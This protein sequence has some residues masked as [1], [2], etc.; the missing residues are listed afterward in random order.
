MKHGIG[1][2]V[3]FLQKS[4]VPTRRVDDVLYGCL[5]CIHQGRTLDASDATVFIS[6]KALF[7]HLARHPR[8][9]PEIPGVVVVDQEF[10]PDD[11]ANN[12]DLHF[13]HPKEIHPVAEKAKEI[14]MLPT[15]V[16]K[17]AARRM[18]GQRLL[19]DRTPA[20]EMVQGAKI[21]GLTWPEKYMGEWAFGWHDGINAS[22]PMEIVRLDQPPASEI[23][24]AGTS[25]IRATARWKFNPKDKDKFKGDWLKFDKDEV[26]SNINCEFSYPVP[27]YISWDITDEEQGRIRIIGAGLV[28]MPRANG[29]S[30]PRRS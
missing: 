5:F 20:L 1:F 28:Q 11:L 27:Q 14:D 22:V 4:H 9:L 17:D 23:K 12:Y 10:I 8:P 15:G 2:R 3:R 26:I 18:Y 6:Q 29:V 30:F 24:M 16:A 25:Q 21:T 13:K 19:F 7:Q